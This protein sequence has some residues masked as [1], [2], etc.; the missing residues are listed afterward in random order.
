MM[1]TELE[2]AVGE[3]GGFFLLSFKQNKKKKKEVILH[4]LLHICTQSPTWGSGGISAHHNWGWFLSPTTIGA[5]VLPPRHKVGLIFPPTRIS[6]CRTPQP[7]P[8]FHPTGAVFQPYHCNCCLL[9]PSRRGWCWHG[10]ALSCGCRQ[11]PR[12]GSWGSRGNSS[13]ACRWSDDV[14]I[15]LSRSSR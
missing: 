8:V 12:S 5:G 6:F 1:G 10:Q 15:A 7:G 11:L 13:T 3:V 14:S 4:Q 9:P 2:L